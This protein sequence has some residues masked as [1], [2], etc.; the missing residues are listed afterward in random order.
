MDQF[1]YNVRAKFP[2]G[3]E[4]MFDSITAPKDYTGQDYLR[5]YAI[6]SVKPGN[7]H[8]EIT[9]D[10]KPAYHIIDDCGTD[11]YTESF[12]HRKKA[13]DTA[14]DAFRSLTRNDLLCRNAFYVI[15][16]DIDR[17]DTWTIIKKYL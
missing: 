9:L 8:P 5:D 15:H 2:D 3:T 10:V 17:P 7:C 6:L 11:T 14:R 12:Y 13:L 16:G 1:Y 4:M